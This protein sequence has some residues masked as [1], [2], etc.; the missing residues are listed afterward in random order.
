MEQGGLTGIRK[1]VTMTHL[2]WEKETWWRVSFPKC[3]KESVPGHLEVKQKS[4]GVTIT[5]LSA[6]LKP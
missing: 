2:G 4:Q 3:Q 1:G 6:Q 5:P